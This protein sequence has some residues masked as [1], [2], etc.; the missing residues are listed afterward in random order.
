MTVN[1][2]S[3]KQTCAAGVRAKIQKFSWGV[4]YYLEQ[5]KKAVNLISSLNILSC[6]STCPSSQPEEIITKLTSNI[7]TRK[8]FYQPNKDIACV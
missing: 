3:S 6:F 2:K 4:T 5:N 1:A 8:K 7:N